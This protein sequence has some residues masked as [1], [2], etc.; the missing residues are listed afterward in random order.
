M[1]IF[2]WKRH[3]FRIKPTHFFYIIS[4]TETKL[5]SA[6]MVSHQLN[7]DIDSTTRRVDSSGNIFHPL[8]ATFV[9]SRPTD[10]VRIATDTAFAFVR[11]P[12][13]LFWAKPSVK[14]SLLVLET[15]YRNSTAKEFAV[16][17]I[18]SRIEANSPHSISGWRLNHAAMFFGPLDPGDK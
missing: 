14:L 13:V 18:W 11:L 2:H 4:R 6:Q 3:F 7:D 8:A 1:D 16:F 15:I 12:L 5:E 17:I 9:G 10:T